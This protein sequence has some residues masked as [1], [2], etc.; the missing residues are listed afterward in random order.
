MQY[1]HAVIFL[2]Y[3]PYVEALDIVQMPSK[4]SAFGR[5]ALA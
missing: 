4:M 3:L 5:Q 2:I 1:T